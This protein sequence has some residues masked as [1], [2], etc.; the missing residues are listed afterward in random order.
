VYYLRDS[1]QFFHCLDHL[2][3]YFKGVPY[4]AVIGCLEEGGFGVLIYDGDDLAP[5]DAGQVLDGP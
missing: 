5:V 3:Y 4:N 1:L 2:W